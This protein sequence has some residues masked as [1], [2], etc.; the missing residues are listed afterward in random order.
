[1]LNNLIVVNTSQ[2]MCV[3]TH[4]IVHFKLMQC[5]NVN[6]I[7]IKLREKTNNK[8]LYNGPFSTFDLSHTFQLLACYNRVLNKIIYVN[9]IQQCLAYG[10]RSTIAH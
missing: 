5:Y 9:H 6:D 3:S 8:V 10:M 4:H 2:Y 1:M 7:S